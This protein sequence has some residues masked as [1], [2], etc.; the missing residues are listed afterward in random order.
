[1][2]EKTYSDKITQVY[3][4]GDQPKRNVDEGDVL[5]ISLLVIPYFLTVFAFIQLTHTVHLN[6]SHVS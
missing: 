5:L 6:M 2:N 3:L 1:M 4:C